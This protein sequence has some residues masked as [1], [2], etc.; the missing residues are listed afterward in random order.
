VSAPEF[1]LG[2]RIRRDRRADA[3]VVGCAPGDD[4]PVLAGGAEDVAAA[5]GEDGSLVELLALAGASGKA[6]EVVKCRAGARSRPPLLVGVGLGPI[7]KNG[8]HEPRH[9]ERRRREAGQASLRAAAGPWPAPVGWSHAVPA[10]PGGRREGSLLGRTVHAV[11]EQRRRQGPVAEFGLLSD[12]ADGRGHSDA[13][14]A[15][16]VR[17]RGTT[18]RNLITRRRTT[19]PGQLRDRGRPTSARPRG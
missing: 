4:G 6:D 2:H 11:Q 5:F 18:A 1:S 15:V 7:K 17:G 19:C 9:G 16:A 13:G 3:L 12:K 8:A 10:G 14:R